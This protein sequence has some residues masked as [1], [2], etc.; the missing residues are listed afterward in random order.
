MSV[1][2][3][4]VK[5]DET[6][7]PDGEYVRAEDFDRA[8]MLLRTISEAAHG[9]NKLGVPLSAIDAFLASVKDG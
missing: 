6:E 2:R 9:P 8:V 7:V 3:W 5:W 1:K 4:R